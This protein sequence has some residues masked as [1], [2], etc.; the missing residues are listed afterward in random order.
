M[1]KEKHS[2]DYYHNTQQEIADALGTSRANVGS[3]EVRALAK[4]K[5][6]LE[7]RGYKMEDLIG[8]MQ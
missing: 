5:S 8:G 4:F 1:K 7:K 2:Y 6:E 3:I